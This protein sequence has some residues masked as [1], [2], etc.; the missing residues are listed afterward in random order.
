MV[1]EAA[2][3]DKETNNDNEMDQVLHQSNDE[4]DSNASTT[5]DSI[6]TTFILE[7][8]NEQTNIDKPSKQKHTEL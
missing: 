1:Q 5:N 8:V 2:K 6:N 3:S 4:I 7:N